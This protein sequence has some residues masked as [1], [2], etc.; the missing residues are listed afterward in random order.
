MQ[1]DMQRLG[2]FAAVVL[3]AWLLQGCQPEPQEEAPKPIAPI[4]RTVAT[5][6]QP[7]VSRD[8][9]LEAWV[10]GMR[11]KALAQGIDPQWW[12]Y[13]MQ[14][15]TPSSKI[16]RLDRKQ[17]E[18]SKP[19]SAYLSTTV[20]KPRIEEGRMLLAK[21]AQALQGVEEAYHVP[22]S[23]IVALWGKETSYGKVTGNFYVPHA[24]ATLAYDGR[25][26]ELFEKELIASLRILQEGHI[27]PEE[28]KGS[29][30]GA[31]GQTQ[32]MPTSFYLYGVDADGDG[33]RDIWNTQADVFASIANYL[34]QSGWNPAYGWGMKVR[35]PADLQAQ[36]DINGF[37]P[38][39]YWKEQGVLLMDGGDLPEDAPELA[40]MVPDKNE[41]DAY[42]ITSNFHVILKW[43]KSRYFATA[44]G[45]LADA[46]RQ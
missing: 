5:L 32:F 29:W 42:L 6:E 45:T 31:M 35:V 38:L 9:T 24:L 2:S 10:A 43:N 27:R 37:K 4:P 44:V 11:A 19:F 1:L 36:E 15:F 16:I 39:S 12:D 3:G 22:A 8:A 46:I 26:A 17:P 18:R 23:I 25:R 30:A 33:K 14:D 34:A 20:A 40:L 28:M 7:P 21:N 41:N 13:V